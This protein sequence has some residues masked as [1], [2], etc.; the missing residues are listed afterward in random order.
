MSQD[1]GEMPADHGQMR[2]SKKQAR[3]VFDPEGFSAQQLLSPKLTQ[4]PAGTPLPCWVTP[5]LN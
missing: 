1:R 5:P 3:T 2:V 4:P